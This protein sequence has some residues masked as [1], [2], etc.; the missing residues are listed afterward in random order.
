MLC[1]LFLSTMAVPT[2]LFSKVNLPLSDQ[3]FQLLIYFPVTAAQTMTVNDAQVSAAS[4]SVAPGPTFWRD[5]TAQAH[6]L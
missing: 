4:D 3:K 5:L 2:L 6:R 1:G